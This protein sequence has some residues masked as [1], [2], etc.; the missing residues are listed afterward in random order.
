VWNINILAEYFLSQLKK[1]EKQYHQSRLQVIADVEI[2]CQQLKKLDSYEVYPTK[3]NFILLKITNGTT[4]HKIQMQLLQEFGVYVRD[5]S[6][7]F[8][9]D[10][11]HMRVASQ[12]RKKGP[13]MNKC[14]A[15]S[16]KKIKRGC[17]NPH[18]PG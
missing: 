2:L 8:D 13:L 11:F 6:D 9:L 3:G 1:T 15:T 10:K 7:K 14:P 16:S 17:R 18:P 5:C 4:A 12:G